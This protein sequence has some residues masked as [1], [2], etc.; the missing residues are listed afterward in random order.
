MEFSLMTEPQLG[1]TYEEILAAAQWA[2][3][4]DL[5]SF[6]RS[7]HYYARRDP[8][9]DATDALTTLAGLARETTRIRLCVLVTPITFRHPAVI[10]K[11]AATLDQMSTGRFDLGV[12]TGWMDLEHEVFGFPFPDWS[13]RFSRLGE[14]LEYLHAA[15]SEGSARF[16]GN[17]YSIDAD[18]K[19]N[20][21]GVRIIVGGTGPTKTPTLAGQR[22]DEYNHIVATPDEIA[23]KIE[24]MRSA[25]ISAGRSSREIAVSVMGQVMVGRDE[26]EYR[27]NVRTAASRG[28]RTEA[29]VEARLR[30]QGIPHGHGEQLKAH[31]D[32]LA[33][34]GVGRYYLQWL[35]VADLDGLDAAYQAVT[36]ANSIL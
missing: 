3:A 4:N 6:A 23:P 15:F 27:A 5:S 8:I 13:E 36:A 34:I 24:V 2:E 28:D 22:A 14:T 31:F 17:H 21:V 12:G 1:G 32:A 30:E 20:P 9:P 16:K 18:V 35:D 7:D 10:A 19:P 26:A 11:T 33:E 25:A 29:E